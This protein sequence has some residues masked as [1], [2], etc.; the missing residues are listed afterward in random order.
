M[1]ALPL[2]AS[3]S[4]QTP[5]PDDPALIAAGMVYVLLCLVGVPA[6]LY[7]LARRRTRA[8]SIRR[9]RLRVLA[10]AWPAPFALMLLGAVGLCYLVGLS[11]ASRMG[12]D[13]E[14]LESD[15]EGF[16]RLLVVQT[17]FMQWAPLLAAVGIMVWM[18]VTPKATPR[19]TSR[20]SGGAAVRAGLLGYLAAMPFLVTVV[21][22]YSW[23]SQQFGHTATSQGLMTLLAG[24]RS[25]W[26]LAYFLFLIII[27]G[28]VVEELLFRRIWLPAVAR[29]L[30]TVPAVL[31]VSLVFA[32]LH[33]HADSLAALFLMGIV[34]SLVYLHTG[35][36]LS[37]IVTHATFNTVNVS[38]LLLGK[39]WGEWPWMG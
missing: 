1:S 13:P 10:S 2:L 26:L 5:A 31:L 34:F 27:L 30:G 17:L 32:L 36:L 7:L 11:T 24:I 29:R 8:L 35:S 9:T 39:F 38:V 4:G 33:G 22:L 16:G 18:A 15:P 14:I 28:P 6:G 19:R 3:A 21:A 23:I 25:P 12:L 20:L 37:A